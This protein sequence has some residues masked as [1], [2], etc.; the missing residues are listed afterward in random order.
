MKLIRNETWTYPPIL[1]SIMNVKASHQLSGGGGGGGG[2][3]VG[4]GGGGGRPLSYFL[5]LEGE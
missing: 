5:E 1:T 3:G 2:E 4:G